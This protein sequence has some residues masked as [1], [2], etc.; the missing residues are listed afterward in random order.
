MGFL[1]KPNFKKHISEIKG[2]TNR[3]VI[4]NL[5]IDYNK[6]VQIQAYAPTASSSD[7][8][9]EI[10]YILGKTLNETRHKKTNKIIIMGYFNSQIGQ[11]TKESEI[12]GT[13]KF[14]KR[15][16]RGWRPPPVL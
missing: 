10:I 3:I 12:M 8:D 9:I 2:I 16:D 4:L 11:H 15:N 14:E 7:K 5:F 6:I 1:V 13:L